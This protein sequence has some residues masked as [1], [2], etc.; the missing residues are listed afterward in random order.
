MDIDVSA[1]LPAGLEE[2]LEIFAAE[3]PEVRFADLDRAALEE[4]VARVRALA[5]GVARAEAAAAA[6]R[7]DLNA[8]RDRLTSK[9][10]RAIAY[11]RIY[12]EGAGLTELVARLEALALGAR[13]RRVDA[14]PSAPS[15]AGQR[16]RGRPPKS[17]LPPEDPVL[18]LDSPAAV[19]G[20]ARS[21]L[22]G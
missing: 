11:A 3:L 9:G 15:D 13:A 21:D 8:A 5:E 10:Q 1:S 20:H 19:N 22:V 14:V 17:G 7:A 2:L 12:A 18:P 6:A 16:R 4:D